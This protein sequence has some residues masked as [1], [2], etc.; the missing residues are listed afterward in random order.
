VA[1]A[2]RVRSAFIKRFSRGKGQMRL[3]GAKSMNSTSAAVPTR[4]ETAVF[5]LGSLAALYAISQFL[6]NSIG[7][8]ANDL[9]RELSLSATQVGL[10]SSTFFFAFAASQIPVGIA[11][12]RY[13]PKRTLLATAVVA[14]A[15]TALFALA[16]SASLLIGARI[17]MGVGCSTFL[18]A[19]FVIFA[20]RFAPERFAGLASLHM[21]LANLGTLA[22]TAPLAA[23]ASA[24]GWRS[25]FMAVAALAVVLALLIVW[26]VPKDAR[27]GKE[28]GSW[29]SALR[30]VGAALKVRSFRQV[31]FV[32]LTTYSSFATIVGLWGGPWLRDVHGADLTARGNILLVGA[33]AQICGMLLWGA[34]DRFWGSY[35]KP[36]LLGGS[37][38]VLLLG[39]L[40]AAPLSLGAVTVWF[41]LFGLCVAYTPILMA[42]GKSLFPP[43]IMGRGMTL[44]NIGTMG[45]AFLSQSV[46]GLLI[47]MAGRSDSGAYRPEGYR[48]VFAALAGWLLLSLVFY[49][50]AIEFHPGRHARKA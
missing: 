25:S 40:A 14:V 21:S 45:G 29:T 22:A 13:G 33:A 36:V 44:M 9:A 35:K 16:P 50:R 23:A 4:R 8:I 39:A 30:G 1:L 17:L 6:R 10:L 47:D 46:T 38:V 32:H 19:P 43:E 34:M 42:H 24:L 15:G 3:E 20:R 2:A 41:G 31:F 26:A 5:L 27:E 7:V 28:R 48:L 12:D 49:V 18:M 11:I 37:A